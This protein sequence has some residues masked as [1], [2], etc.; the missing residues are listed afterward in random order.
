[1]WDS[2]ACIKIRVW[3]IFCGQCVSKNFPL[4]VEKRGLRIKEGAGIRR[5]WG[6]LETKRDQDWRIEIEFPER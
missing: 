4:G 3:M 2:S 1:M 6:T 5:P